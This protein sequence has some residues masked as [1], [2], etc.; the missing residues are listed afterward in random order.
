MLTAKD[1]LAIQDLPRKEVHI[2]EW[3]GTVCVRALTG[4]ERDHL[5]RV[6]LQDKTSRAAIA[7]LC[8]VDEQGNRLFKDSDLEALSQKNGNALE[9]IVK[10][11]LAFNAISDEGINEAGKV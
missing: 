8:C 6:I 1:I 4:A 11:A 3:N 9:R 7:V 5:E 10:S 2:P